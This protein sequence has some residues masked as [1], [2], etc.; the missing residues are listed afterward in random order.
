MGRAKESTPQF[1]GVRR[2]RM[3]PS[4]LP[5]GPGSA[6]GADAG[7]EG[8]VLPSNA[9]TP[10]QPPGGAQDLAVP[11]IAKRRPRRRNKPFV[12]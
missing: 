2:R 1:A 5:V 6:V 4:D 7:N 8:E 9:E 3:N 10:L 11:P 12:L